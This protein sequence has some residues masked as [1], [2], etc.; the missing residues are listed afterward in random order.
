M[1]PWLQVTEVMSEQGRALSEILDERIARYPVSGE[2]NLTLND[3]ALAL[4]AARARY[5]PEA[6]G[7][8][9]LDGLS[10][11]FPFWRFNVRTSNTEPVVRVNVETRGDKALLDAK[12]KEVLDTLESAS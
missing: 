9:E 7:I 12:T 4:S 3:P 1:I 11:E 8:D 10:V 5:E 2:I 6:L